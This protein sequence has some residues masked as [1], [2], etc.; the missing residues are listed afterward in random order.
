MNMLFFFSS[1]RR[2]TRYW[3]D[4]SSDVCSS[5]LIQCSTSTTE[6]ATL[7]LNA[8]RGEPAI[9]EFA[10]PFT[11]YHRSSPM[12]STMVGSALHKVLPLLQPAHGKITRLR[13]YSMRLKRPIKTRFRSGSPSLVNLATYHNSLA[14]SSKGTPS[15]PLTGRRFD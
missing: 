7:H 15:R 9:T 8:F 1:R 4:W 6:H 14:H 13:V 11:P 12:F 3:R 2:H 10:W 5:D